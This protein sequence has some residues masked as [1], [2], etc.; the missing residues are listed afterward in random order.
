VLFAQL[1]SDLNPPTSASQLTGI[2]GMSHHTQLDV[3]ILIVNVMQEL[4][5][6]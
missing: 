2:T 4:W 6:L 5:G 1:G 3:S